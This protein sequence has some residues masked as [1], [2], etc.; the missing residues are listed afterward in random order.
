MRIADVILS[1]YLCARI[2]CLKKDM[3]KNYYLTAML[4]LIFLSPTPVLADDVKTPVDSV[5]VRDIE[6]VVVISTPKEN[7]N[8]R[9]QTL[10]STSQRTAISFSALSALLQES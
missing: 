1:P 9:Q 4:G 10:S 8:L 2:K 5:I 6:E 7:Q 3:K